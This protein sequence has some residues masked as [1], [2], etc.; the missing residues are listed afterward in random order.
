LAAVEPASLQKYKIFPYSEN[1]LSEY[2]E[3]A[4]VDPAGSKLLGSGSDPDPAGS[5]M[6]GSGMDP[7]LAR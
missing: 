3:L 2:T 4:G 5:D 1:N 7:D 6:S